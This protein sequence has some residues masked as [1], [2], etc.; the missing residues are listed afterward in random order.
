MISVTPSSSRCSTLIERV[1]GVSGFSEEPGFV[2]RFAPRQPESW[3]LDSLPWLSN[4]R[5]IP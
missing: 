1:S 3:V 4:G 5:Y 2:P